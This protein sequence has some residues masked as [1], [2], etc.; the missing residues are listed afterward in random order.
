MGVG[1]PGAIS[2]LWTFHVNVKLHV[3]GNHDIVLPF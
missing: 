1:N 2:P 3:G